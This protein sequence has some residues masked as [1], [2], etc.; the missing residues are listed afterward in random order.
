MSNPI[1]GP[2]IVTGASGQLGSQVVDALLAQGAAPIVA[3]TRAPEKLSTLQ[4]RGVEVRAADFNDAAS[5][6]PAFTGGGRLLIISTD[7]RPVASTR[8]GFL[9]RRATGLNAP[10]ARNNGEGALRS[11]LRPCWISRSSQH[12]WPRSL[13]H[14]HPSIF[15]A[16]VCDSCLRFK[17][18]NIGIKGKISYLRTGLPQLSV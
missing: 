15:T 14:H 13:R 7:A 3:I 8:C 11:P 2:F 6:V 5:L 4:A 10:G 17:G 9:P 16:K 1:A 18:K 12:Q